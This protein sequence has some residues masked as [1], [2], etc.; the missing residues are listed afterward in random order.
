VLRRSIAG[1]ILLG[2][3][4][5]AS[6]AVSEPDIA[7][8]EEK[9]AAALDTV[10]RK[11]P[12]FM[13][14]LEAAP[15]YAVIGMSETKI[16]GVGTGLGYGVIVDNRS[17]DHHYL[18]ITQLEVGAGLGAKR[19]KIIV[20][21]ENTAPLDRIIRGGVR[22]E[23]AADVEVVDSGADSERAL[24]QKAGKGYEVYRLTESGAVATVTVRMLQGK[25][26]HPADR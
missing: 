24:T 5:C 26:Y 13:D 4:G 18:R 2:I 12:G 7:A 22:F 19:S 15:G 14:R 23:S 1:V 17:G 3:A 9:A 21:F 20:L 11:S 8:L 6:Q 10:E 16:P 25:P